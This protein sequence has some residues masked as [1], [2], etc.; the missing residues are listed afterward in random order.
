MIKR[1]LEVVSALFLMVLFLPLLVLIGILVKTTSQ[2]P[3][4]FRQLR[5]GLYGRHFVMYKFRTLRDGT[6]S[7]TVADLVCENDSRVTSIGH[8]LRR[9]HLDELLQLLNILSGEMTFVGPRPITPEIAKARFMEHSGYRPPKV[10]P[11]VTGLRQICEREEVLWKQHR[12]FCLALDAWYAENKTFQIDCWIILQ[13]LLIPLFG[14]W[15]PETLERRLG[16]VLTPLPSTTANNDVP[17]VE[18]A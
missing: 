18:A 5:E 1:L 10:L 16:I 14:K 11:G 3:V 2:G 17:T 12:D 13:T 6:G 8:F 15:R 7:G 9:T 4:I